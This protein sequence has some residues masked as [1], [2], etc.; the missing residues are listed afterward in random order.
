MT[1]NLFRVA[2]VLDDFTIV[3]NKGAHDGLSLNDKFLIFEEGEDVIDPESGES[4][5]PIEIVKGRVKVVHLQERVCTVRSSET[6]KIPGRKRTIERRDAWSIAM[7]N[8][9]REEIEEDHSYKEKPLDNPQIG[10]FA[11]PY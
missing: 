7:G 11:R 5:G 2:R 8:Q 4:L 6:I 1:D 3:L 10:D 9:A